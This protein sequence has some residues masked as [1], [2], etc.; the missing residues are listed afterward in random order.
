MP[1]SKSRGQA[2]RT[3]VS[4]WGDTLLLPLLKLCLKWSREISRLQRSRSS[5]FLKSLDYNL[6]LGGI[7]VRQKEAGRERE[8]NINL[9][10]GPLSFHPISLAP[11]LS[12][13]RF[14]L[15][16]SRANAENKGENE[17]LLSQSIHQKQLYKRMAGCFGAKMEEARYLFKGIHSPVIKKLPSFFPFSFRSN[18]LLY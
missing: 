2:C 10:P 14:F 9:N 3:D 13:P 8:R 17:S 1:A 16:L 5:K 7:K 11:L 18:S 15:E 12:I 6:K 4:R